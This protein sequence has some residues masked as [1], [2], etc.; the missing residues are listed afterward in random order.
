LTELWPLIATAVFGL[1]AWIYEKT[2]TRRAERAKYYG[3]IID[4]FDGFLLNT[5]DYS[6]KR[7]AAIRA[8]RHCWLS[9]PVYV[10]RAGNKFL[11]AA[12]GDG[13][14]A[15]LAWKEFV[16]AMRKDTSLLAVLNPFRRNKLTTADIA[17]FSSNDARVGDRS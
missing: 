11:E 6:D 13:A 10:V 3:D 9:A 12:K 2:W 4:G 15:E 17:I 14:H 7:N 8:L 5:R 16:L 1:L